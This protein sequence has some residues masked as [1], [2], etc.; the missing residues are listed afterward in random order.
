MIRL[1]VLVLGGVHEGALPF[2]VHLSVEKWKNIK[3]VIPIIIQN[4]GK[5]CGQR[6]YS[7]M[8]VSAGI[9]WTASSRAGAGRYGAQRWYT[10]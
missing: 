3:K 5:S 6:R 7:G 1:V 10:M 9:V 4:D 2:L 8:A